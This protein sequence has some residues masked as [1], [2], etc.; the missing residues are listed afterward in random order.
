MPNIPLIYN[1]HI[2]RHY[3]APDHL[4]RALYLFISTFDCDGSL[5]QEL[6]YDSYMPRGHEE[7]DHAEFMHP[8]LSIPVHK[9]NTCPR[10]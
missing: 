9:T 4:F 8:F 6:R 5:N 3:I 2:S 1:F 7:V 10:K